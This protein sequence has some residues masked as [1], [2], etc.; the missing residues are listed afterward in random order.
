M[1][2]ID[3]RGREVPW[4]LQ[5]C[6]VLG[7]DTRPRSQLH[8]RAREV[9]RAT[10]PSEPVLEEV[11]IPGT[12]LRADF[13]LPARRLMVE[14]QGSQHYRANARHHKTTA[15]FRAQLRRDAEKARFCEINGL[16]LVLF[17]HDQPDQRWAELLRAA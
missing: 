2:V 13:F 3:L 17:D 4:N 7:D 14:V 16:T 11:P 6:R 9:I 1:R 12:R 8:L 5:G 15:D 10:L